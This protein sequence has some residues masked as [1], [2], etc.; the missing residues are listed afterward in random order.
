[1]D[2]ESWVEMR[3]PAFMEDGKNPSHRKVERKV[4]SS[5]ILGTQRSQPDKEVHSIPAL[6]C[7]LAPIL[8]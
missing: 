6:W 1:M 3:R 8:L 5:A 7:P 2:P 4:I